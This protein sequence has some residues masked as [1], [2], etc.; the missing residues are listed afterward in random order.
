MEVL[1]DAAF[2]RKAHGVVGVRCF[3]I[4]DGSHDL[5]RRVLDIIEPRVRYVEV[6]ASEPMTG[7]WKVDLLIPAEPGRASD[8]TRRQ[9]VVLRT[10]EH[11]SILEC[12]GGS[13]CHVW[14]TDSEQAALGA[15]PEALIPE[16]G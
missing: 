11:T 3:R 16:S 7:S 4:P 8:L 1:C 5:F 9:Y 6:D 12:Y 2:K 13:L 15:R 10:S 14:L